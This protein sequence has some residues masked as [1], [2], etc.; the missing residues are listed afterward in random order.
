MCWV[1]EE[2]ESATKHRRWIRGVLEERDA[3]KNK[4][5]CFPFKASPSI[6]IIF[7]SLHI[8]N[9]CFPSSAS[10]SMAILLKLIIL[11]SFFFNLSLFF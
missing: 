6:F 8:R 7:I 11:K 1:E 4:L 9:S 5:L 10:L 2:A 3:V